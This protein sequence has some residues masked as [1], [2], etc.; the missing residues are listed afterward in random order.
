MPSQSR[1][2]F[3][4][5]LCFLFVGVLIGIAI[6]AGLRPNHMLVWVNPVG[7][8]SIA[9]K[10]GDTIE[11]KQFPSNT[12][13][14]IKF[15]GNVLPPCRKTTNPCTITDISDIATY[16][17]S[18]TGTNGLV[19]NDPQGGPP[20]PTGGLIF[21]LKSFIVRIVDLVNNVLALLGQIFGY[22]PHASNP[23]AT[24]NTPGNAPN[25]EGHVATDQARI[26]KL[27]A[28]SSNIYATV[29]CESDKLTHVYAQNLEDK[30]II[31]SNGQNNI[32]WSS[33]VALTISLTSPP[34]PV[35]A[36]TCSPLT[37]YGNEW[38]CTDPV[39]AGYYTA[40]AGTCT[41]ANEQ[42]TLQP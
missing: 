40:Q 5:C 26:S 29:T 17:Y 27:S 6:D 32:L 12:P 18:C 33:D 8:L 41:A 36:A 4:L 15:Q 20:P 2:C 30:P 25:T 23:G 35:P 34:T 24:Q 3:A 7:D 38:V 42:I 9:F 37:Q 13:V 21:T 14:A 10:P 1:K 39:T 16:Y 11:W 19:C 28:T 31:N 22:S